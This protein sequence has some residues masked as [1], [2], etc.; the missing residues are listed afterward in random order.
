MVSAGP[1]NIINDTAL[2]W[3]T[4]VSGGDVTPEIRA[5]LDAWLAADTRHRGAF[6]RAQAWILA[7]EDAV[8]A[9]HPASDRAVSGA[10]PL[11][12]DDSHTSITAR[13]RATPLRSGLL[14]WGWRAATGGMALMACLIVAIA[15]DV[16]LLSPFQPAHVAASETLADGSTVTFSSDARIEVMLSP[17]YR[18]I[19]LLSGEATFHVAK[20]KSRPFVVQS[21]GVY[22]QATGTVYSVRRIGKTGGTV[23]VTQGSVL[24]WPGDERDQAVLLR[25]GG[26][27]TLEPGPPS[28]PSATK[29]APTEPRLP[30]PELAQISLDNVTIKDAAARFNRVNSTKIVVT[31]ARIA[32]VTI[33][34]LYK[35]SDPEQ[36]AKAAATIANGH[37]RMESSV[38]VIFM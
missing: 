37:V 11:A 1:T 12:L 23:K 36:F 15:L 22:A 3:A 31:D 8:I 19:T 10:A 9:A 25:A 33:T 4:E 35:A 38:I 17:E 18:R 13:S 5:E 14:R 28:A 20:D 34:G 16:P 24:V 32:N 2:H 29:S 30:P 21:G 7:T 6:M 27:V 26:T